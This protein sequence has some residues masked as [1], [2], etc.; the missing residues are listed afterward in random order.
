MKKFSRTLL[1]NIGKDVVATQ[2]YESNTK[3]LKSGAFVFESLVEGL[4]VPSVSSLSEARAIQDTEGKLTN[5]IMTFPGS[6]AGKIKSLAKV[7][8]TVSK[9]RINKP[10]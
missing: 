5:A 1:K 4:E 2:F 3:V 8:Q 9:R 10:G 6:P 7:E